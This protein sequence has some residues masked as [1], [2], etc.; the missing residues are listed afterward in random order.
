[1][2]LL[3]CHIENF[4]RL[5]DL[6]ID[7]TDGVNVICKENG[8][9]KS[10]LGAFLKAMF[11]GFDS[12]KGRDAI[13]GERKLYQPWQ[14][15]TYGGEVLFE[16]DGK[17]FFI[18]RTFGKSERT[19]TFQLFD[20]TTNL[21]D[22]TYSR[23][24][25]EELFGLDRTSFGRSVF[26]AQ[27]H[28]FAETTDA[29]NAK[30]GNLAENTNDINNYETAAGHIKEEMN[31]L[32]PD[33]VTGSIKKRKSEITE[34][35]ERLRALSAVE[36]AF[37]EKKNLLTEKEEEKAR[38]TAERNVL[39]RQLKEAGEAGKQEALKTQYDQ[40]AYEEKQKK[41]LY[42]K[43]RAQFPG[44]VPKQKELEE[45][46][47]DART[48][49]R[50]QTTAANFA[51]TE[52]E[53]DAYQN[54]KRRFER[55]ADSRGPELSDEAADETVESR[56]IP[57]ED[58]ARIEQEID[59]RK[60]MLDEAAAIERDLTACERE[61]LTL[62]NEIEKQEQELAFLKPDK[63]AER[64]TGNGSGK[65]LPAVS[66]LILG[67]AAVCA[68]F[69]DAKWRMPF[70][71]AGIAFL[72]I[73]AVAAFSSVQENKKKELLRQQEQ[74]QQRNAYQAKEQD[75]QQKK[76]RLAQLLEECASHREEAGH[77]RQEVMEF[78]AGYGSRTDAGH[79]ADAL[80]ELK[81]AYQE[82]LRGKEKENQ[83]RAAEARADR[84]GEKIG[85]LLQSF[86]ISP[87]PPYASQISGLLVQAADCRSAYQ[88]WKESKEKLD[89][90]E[91]EHKKEQWSTP[92][93][94]MAS[95]EELNGQIMELDQ[96]LEK[97][98]DT[99][100]TYKM[101]L[102]DLQEEL[103][104][105]DELEAELEDKTACQE[106]DKKRYETLKLTQQYLQAA[107]EQFTARY[108][109]PVSNGFAEYYDFLTALDQTEGNEGWMVDANM[110]LKVKEQGQFRETGWL[111]AGC[112]DLIGF[113]MRLALVDAMYQEEKPFLLLDDPFVNL[114][115]AKTA[116]GNKL[117]EK[118]G[119]T[120][121]VIYFTCHDSRIPESN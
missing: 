44:G 75:V 104:R 56:N 89:Q 86:E 48:L 27:S 29:I 116:Q 23:N 25:G 74:T 42:R 97:I 33:R 22:D 55:E 60:E 12:K 67:A 77:M 108:M 62:Q 73:G 47:A 31:K 83:A 111:S 80:F 40:L 90:F 64:D 93:Q 98:M 30:L 51:F 61:R 15:G 32:T 58:V 19:D 8:W 95:V 26:I 121:Q 57:D 81:S 16:T 65:L 18:S 118:L 91:A 63:E 1:M 20:G 85:Q 13:A 120:Y 66:F 24:I 101:Q 7:F 36:D 5:S 87:E 43:L 102:D 69:V 105:R 35:S 92:K 71:V 114:D 14:G 107:K 113:C 21:P 10:T 59:R 109:A 99:I 46:L 82:Y 72:V 28:V 9:G 45:A 3:T 115:A 70:L 34:L 76:R 119:K 50:Y 112:Q 41:E 79:E 52:A 53:K 110:E 54:A 38:V 78:L 2:K 117:I 17:R 37:Q 49:A 68:S 106:K 6:T 11:Y 100:G 94:D 4:G 103:D 84:L 96:T 39:S 88:M